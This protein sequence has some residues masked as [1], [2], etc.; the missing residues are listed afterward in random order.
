M[1][2]TRCQVN[3]LSSAFGRWI[4]LEDF[5]WSSL[6]SAVA[7]WDV[8]QMVLK[9]DLQRLFPSNLDLAVG[10]LVFTVRVNDRRFSEA[11]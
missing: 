3:F 8:G 10:V 6:R 1:L 9:P 7:G 5:L 11:C 4:W 2:K